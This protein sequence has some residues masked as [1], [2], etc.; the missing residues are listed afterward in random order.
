MGNTRKDFVTS[1]IRNLVCLT[2]H[3][4]VDQ[5]SPRVLFPLRRGCRRMDVRGASAQDC[6][7]VSKP[8]S[9]P[10]RTRITIIGP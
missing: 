6:L 4:R 3:G 9:R 2:D 7:V 5:A 10:F 8:W 1:T